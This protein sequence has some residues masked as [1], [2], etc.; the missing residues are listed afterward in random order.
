[1][2]KEIEVQELTD[3]Q[4][5]RVICDNILA[6]LPDWF[7]SYE[8]YEE[9]LDDLESR[10]VFAVVIGQETAGIMALTKTSNA[11]IDIHLMAVTPN[12][13][14]KGIGRALVKRAAEFARSNGA[15][16]LTVKT[17]GPSLV[18]D[19]YAR[20]RRFYEKEGFLP[21]EEFIDFW[22]EG[23]PMLLLCQSID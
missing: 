5:N 8:T 10:P 20:T 3:Y 4:E 17:I 6:K 9:Y 7:G 22:G 14:G 1:M 19:A 2:P 15:K 11:S 18:N 23:Y 16:Y 12:E 13:H 21:I